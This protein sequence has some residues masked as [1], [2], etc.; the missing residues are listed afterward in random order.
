MIKD[1]SISFLGA[2]GRGEQIID[3][4]FSNLSANAQLK[5]LHQSRNLNIG[6]RSLN[7]VFGGTR[8]M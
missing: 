6:V 3:T 1:K 2:D 7:E 4:T 8:F 5:S